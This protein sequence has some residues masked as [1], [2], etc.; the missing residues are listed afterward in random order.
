MG[1][2]GMFHAPNDTGIDKEMVAAAE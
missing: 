1:F 2:T